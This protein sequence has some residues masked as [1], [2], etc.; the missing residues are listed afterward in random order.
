MGIQKVKNT[1]ELASLLSK[2]ADVFLYFRDKK[3]GRPPK[4]NRQHIEAMLVLSKTLLDDIHE[5]LNYMLPDLGQIKD[6]IKIFEYLS[7][8]KRRYVDRI[9]YLEKYGIIPEANNDDEIE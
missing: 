1:S 5:C 4:V 6:L 9:N 8:V 3:R 7:S 2:S